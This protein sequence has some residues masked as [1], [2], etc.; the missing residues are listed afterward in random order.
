MD[1]HW[2]PDKMECGDVMSGISDNIRSCQE[3]TMDS[4]VSGVDTSDKLDRVDDDLASII[5]EVMS[6]QVNILVL[7]FGP[8]TFAKF[9]IWKRENLT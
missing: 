2:S 9:G 8:G 5:S 4:G 7:Y 6:I 1:K 3:D